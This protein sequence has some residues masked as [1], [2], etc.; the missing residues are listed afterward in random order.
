[1]VTDLPEISKPIA[2]LCAL[3]NCFI[4][5]GLGTLLMACAA[6]GSISKTQICIAALQVGLFGFFMSYY[7]AY[8]ILKKAFMS[9]DDKADSASYVD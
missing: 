6:E 5:P 7:W 8:L 3:C 1:M 2:V 4:F 9:D